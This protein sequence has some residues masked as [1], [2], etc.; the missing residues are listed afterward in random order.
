MGMIK[1]RCLWTSSIILV[2]AVLTRKSALAEGKTAMPTND[3]SADSTAAQ[4]D[5]RIKRDYGF[6]EPEPLDFNEHQ[7]YVQIFDGV[8]L[9]NWDGDPNTWHVEEG[10]IVGESTKEKPLANSYISFHGFESRDFDLKFEIRVENG[11]GS[12]IQYRSQVGLPWRRKAPPGQTIPDLRW[13]M[14]GPQADFWFPVTPKTSEW[15]GQFYSENTPLGILAWRGQVVESSPGKYPKLLADIGNRDALGGYIKVN[16][17]NQYLIVARGG[18][19]I[20]VINGQLMAVYV[21]D[22][23]NS[24][25][26]KPGLIGIEIEGVPT[27]V[28]VR[29]IWI[30]KLN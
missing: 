28:S 11:G 25:N 22:D 30:K 12:G 2:L 17:W 26:N 21:D 13:M 7:G 9:K 29:N 8:S 6:Y 3:P 15:T 18:T 1:H 4:P 20:H 5:K 27:K 19:F 14:T 16:D 23:P 24:S 10:A